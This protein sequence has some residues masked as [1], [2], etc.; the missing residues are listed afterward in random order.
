MRED[1]VVLT[2]K[3][4]LVQLRVLLTGLMELDLESRAEIDLMLNPY[5]EFLD[6]YLLARTY[7]LLG[8]II[9]NYYSYLS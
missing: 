3:Q 9:K 7:A 2:E 5:G 8:T 1:K 6:S 4:L